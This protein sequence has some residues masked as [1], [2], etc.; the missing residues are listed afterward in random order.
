[1]L[2][3]T[4]RFSVSVSYLAS[5]MVFCRGILECSLLVISHS[6]EVMKQSWHQSMS[7]EVSRINFTVI[8]CL[9][10]WPK[11]K[12]KATESKQS[13]LTWSTLPS[14]SIVHQCVSRAQ[15]RHVSCGLHITTLDNCVFYN[16]LLS[17]YSA[18]HINRSYQV[19]WL[20]SWSPSEL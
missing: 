7:T 18:I 8:R 5:C 2:G 9:N 11:L 16:Y 13:L 19:L 10:Y 17:S 4:S 12:E 14:L 15:V 3:S 6:G 1:M 20:R